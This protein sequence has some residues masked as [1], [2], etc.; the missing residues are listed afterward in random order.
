MAEVR[1]GGAQQCRAPTSRMEARQDE[2]PPP[3]ADVV[4]DGGTRQ[5]LSASLVEVSADDLL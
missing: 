4:F 5:E 2:H 1:P 3:V